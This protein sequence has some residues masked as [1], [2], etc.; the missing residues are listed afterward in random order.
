[1]EE[2]KEL[3]E[4]DEKSKEEKIKE[5]TDQINELIK[6]K[7]EFELSVR[8]SLLI[9]INKIKYLQQQIEELFNQ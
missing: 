9:Y 7:E 1:M 2:N 3:I 4:M 5:Y 8:T 6:E